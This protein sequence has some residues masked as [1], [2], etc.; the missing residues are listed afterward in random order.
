MNA[1]NHLATWEIWHLVKPGITWASWKLNEFLRFAPFRIAFKVDVPKTECIY[2][3][4][5]SKKLNEFLP[6]ETREAKT[7]WKIKTI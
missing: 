6:G 1:W 5:I 2:T 3:R 4:E 7:E